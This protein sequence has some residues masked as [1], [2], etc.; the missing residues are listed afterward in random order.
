MVEGFLSEDRYAYQRA[1]SAEI[2]LAAADH[3]ASK[4]KEGGRPTDLVGLDVAGDLDSAP[5][6]SLVQSL[7]H[8]GIP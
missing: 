6:Q 1:R 2:L 5:H 4:N 7:Q 8:R 3:A